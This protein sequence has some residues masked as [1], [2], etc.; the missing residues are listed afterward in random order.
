MG[1]RDP[2]RLVAAAGLLFCRNW[3]A[4]P[5]L[6]PVLPVALLDAWVAN[7]SNE[8]PS[9]GYCES[10]PSFDRLRDRDAIHFAPMPGKRYQ[11]SARQSLVQT[12]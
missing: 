1:D 2:D 9:V 5:N 4:P 10:W 8:A 7:E 6:P 11:W 12:S 3:N